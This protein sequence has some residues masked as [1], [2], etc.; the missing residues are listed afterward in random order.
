MKVKTNKK[1]RFKPFDLIIT[2]ESEDELNTINL[3]WQ[4]NVGVPKAVFKY[5]GSPD[6]SKKIENLLFSIR[7]ALN[8]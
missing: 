4:T 2:I 8:A 3:L 5:D 6:I 7:K 1:P